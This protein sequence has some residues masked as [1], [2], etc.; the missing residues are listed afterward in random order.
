MGESILLHLEKLKRTTALSLGAFSMAMAAPVVSNAVEEEIS[1]EEVVVTGSRIIRKDLTSTSPI[2]VIDSSEITF[3]GT[4]R[5]EDLVSSLPQAFA[6]QNSTVANGSTGTATV[7]L[8]HLGSARTLVLINGRRMTSGDPF[9]P[10]A[11]LN[12]IPSQLVKR[13]EVLTGGASSVYGS[14]AV[15]GVVNFILNTDFEGFKTD[16]RYSFY[17]HN[18]RNKEMQA[19]NA[20]KGFDFPTGNII[21]GQT[22]DLSMAVGSSFADD[23]GHASAYITYRKIGEITKA[24]RDYTNCTVQ[25]GSTGPRC[26]GS[27]T[28]PRGRFISFNSD[29]GNK[30]D[31]VLDWEGGGTTFRPRDGEVFNYGPFNHIQR[32]DSTWYGGGFVN[33]EFN[34]DMTGYV[35]V[36]FMDN[37][38]EAQIAPTGNFGRTSKINCDNPLL[39]AQQFDEVCTQQGY[40]PTDI[41]NL[42]ILRRNIEGGPRSNTIRHTSYRLVGGLKGEIN[43]IW[44]Y[45]VHGMH[46]TSSVSESYINDM[47]VGRIKDA[48][49]V[50]A[51]PVTG[52]AVCRSG[53]A[54]CVPW[55]IFQQGGVT[56]EAVDYMTTVAVMY[57]STTTNMASAS[58]TGDLSDYGVKLPWAEDG[59]QVAFGVEH[60]AETLNATP[61]EVY[62]KGLRAGSGGRTPPVD[63]SFNVSD[64][65]AEALVPLL[66][67]REMVQELSMELA[68]RYSEYNR[69]GGTNTYKIAMTW[70]PIDDVKF[71]AG[72][73]R[74]VR[75][76]NLLDLFRPQGFGLGGNEDICA[77]DPATGVPSASAA[78]CANT[79]VSASQYGN[80]IANPAN[81]YNT[82]GG[83]NPNLDPEVAD[84][85]TV[86]VVLT[87]AA[88]PG[89]SAT[90]DY[91]KIN[92]EGAIGSLGADDII[93]T[94]ANTGDALLCGLINRD[95]AGT[96][97]LTNDAFTETTNQNIGK[98]GNSGIDVNLNYSTEIGDLGDVNFALVG[99]YLLTNR[100]SNPLTDYDCVGFYGS[101]CGQPDAKWRHK[102]RMT[103]D[104]RFDTTISINWRFIGSS[105]IDDASPDSDLAS[106]GSMAKWE[107]N[108]IAKLNAAS[109]FDLS[110][111]HDI[112]DH[113]RANI[114]VNN[115]LDSEPPIMPSISSTG[116]SGTYDTLGRYIYMGLKAHF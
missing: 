64:I 105:Q 112:N 55:N 28:T 26:G 4:T 20:D 90:I 52:Q 71:R 8:R 41:A 6:A 86:G 110:I 96:L 97:W 45:D 87:P 24:G 58:F 88:L 31:L 54:G 9:A 72:Y 1:L 98:L 77:N 30:K 74:A 94:C 66:Q 63:G 102:L 7:S 79:G 61:D 84:T 42:T 46:M 25:A 70:Q 3:T 113:L 49:D 23:K 92:I 43:D 89:F 100:F 15:A 76:P 101:Q 39:S 116:Y 62:S 56:Q 68:Y 111:T 12:F 95:A 103:W 18:N 2:T 37:Y 82:L 106:P 22:L 99:T 50:I 80:I 85:Y 36:M 10:A 48:L 17:Q 65:F 19:I 57:G 33:Y 11:D 34:P 83:G 44:S 27:S 60:R 73:N 38:T 40:G 51:D 78:E 21:D 114:G 53:N 109:F 67:G 47:N 93:Q 32:P 108:D 13:V 16:V 91:Y 14:D 75:A 115:I 35:E 59:I 69:F 5:I 81:Q 104:T 29:F 107:A